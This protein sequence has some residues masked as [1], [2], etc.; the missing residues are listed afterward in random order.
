MA[1]TMIINESKTTQHSMINSIDFQYSQSSSVKLIN[2]NGDDIKNR[3]TFDLDEMEESLKDKT[4]ILNQTFKRA[5]KIVQQ[6]NEQQNIDLSKLKDDNKKLSVGIDI[7]CYGSFNAKMATVF[8]TNNDDEAEMITNHIGHLI[9]PF[10]CDVDNDFIEWFN[11][12]IKLAFRCFG[13]RWY[14]LTVEERSCPHKFPFR[15]VESN[16]FAF[17]SFKSNEC[18][19]MELLVSIFMRTMLRCLYLTPKNWNDQLKDL[20][21][22]VPSD[23][24]TYQRITLKK[25]FKNIGL[26]SYRIVNKSTALTLPFLT[27][28]DNNNETLVIDFGSG[29]MN[30]SILS[31]NN[32]ELKV[33][34][35]LSARDIS[36]SQ[37]FENCF[38]KL[39]SNCRNCLS[40]PQLR[41][42]LYRSMNCDQNSSSSSIKETWKIPITQQN[43]TSIEINMKNEGAIE[44]ASK[45]IDRFHETFLICK[46]S[47]KICD[48]IKK[49]L[50]C[51]DAV[52]YEFL[53]PLL[54]Y[55]CSDGTKIIFVDNDCASLGAAYLASNL[56]GINTVEMLP[57]SIGM[58]LYNGV[59]KRL[60]DAKTNFPCE[61]HHIFSTIIDKQKIMRINVFEGESPLARNCKHIGELVI[62]NLDKDNSNNNS[63]RKRIQ[64]IVE[65]NSYGAMKCTANDTTMDSSSL[66]VKIDLKT[67][68]YSRFERDPNEE[69]VLIDQRISY[70]VFSQQR[71]LAKLLQ[72]LNYF[73]EYLLYVYRKRT[74][75][76]LLRIVKKNETNVEQNRFEIN[77][78]KDIYSALNK[79]LLVAKAYVSKKRLLITSDECI[80]LI[81]ELKQ[82]AIELNINLKINENNYSNDKGFNYDPLNC[83]T[84]TKTCTIL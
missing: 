29:Y 32:N 10:N 59:I 68:N 81:E 23:F 16:Q 71:Q 2:K 84:V 42:V 69:T 39:R 18:Y 82:I 73:C 8:M 5:F 65:F 51:S 22:T 80:H 74:R 13:K 52:I 35:Q 79:K 9:A 49:I 26:K 28:K 83:E 17:V 6:Q 76:E 37:L 20:F 77:R 43:E 31:L 66:N 19:S 21:V 27:T 41:D 63:N 55:Y 15:I 78:N 12:L 62:T 4:S 7:V 50:I 44:L 36:S 25:C 34:D 53:E 75:D 45:V 72:D 24:H 33:I 47:A 61:G 38:T 11:F 14:E 46:N 70:R 56:K 58:G 1:T 54:K 67:L 3:V 60:C 64:L 48:D 40:D 57:F 30:C